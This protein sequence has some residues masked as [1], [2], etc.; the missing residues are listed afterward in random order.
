YGSA[1]A[2]LGLQ[3]QTALDLRLQ[4]I[5]EEV[6]RDGLTKIERRLG[7]RRVVRRIAAD[8]IEDFLARQRRSRT[9]DGPQEAVVTSVDANAVHIRTPWEDG[10]VPRTEDAAKRATS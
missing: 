5:A 8:E 2:T 7:K 3:V 10:I 6:L 9:P 4:A 1:F